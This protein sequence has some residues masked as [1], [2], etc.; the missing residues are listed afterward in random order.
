MAGLN[1][2]WLLAGLPVFLILAALAWLALHDPAPAPA[3]S[4]PGAAAAP[5]SAPETRSP[6]YWQDIGRD[7]A[8]V[9]GLESLPASLAGTEVPGGLA[10]DADG[11]LVVNGALRAMFEYFLS[12]VGEE[13]IERIIG[14]IRAHLAHH[15]PASAAAEA[16][17]ILDGYLAWRASLADLPQAGGGAPEQLDLDAVRAQQSAARALRGRFLDA[18]TIEAFFADED[19]WD[20]YTL[21]RLAVMQDPALDTQEKAARSAALRASLPPQVRE[22]VEAVSLYN[23]LTALTR[24]LRDRGGSQAELRA[25][26]EQVVGAEAADRLERLE[27]ERQAL[28]QRL[29]AWLAARSALQAAPGLSAADRAAQVDH[30]RAQHFP[31]MDEARVRALEDIADQGGLDTLDP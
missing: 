26:R 28:R 12:A 20:D 9:T 13:D 4:G 11:R 24:E 29:D 6:A 23:D 7:A 22:Q 18:G 30:L 1:R 3:A 10:A 2:R 31:D 27:S 5:A 25:L 17:A 14:R 16:N 21:E 8:F 19:A 15:L